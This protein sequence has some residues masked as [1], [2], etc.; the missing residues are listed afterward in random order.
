MAPYLARR[1]TRL[2]AL[3][4]PKLESMAAS[5][6]AASLPNQVMGMLWR[7][8]LLA[9]ALA[10]VIGITDVLGWALS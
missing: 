6:A 4:C 3:L 8:V 1:W 10:G 7:W 5:A 2:R 9:G